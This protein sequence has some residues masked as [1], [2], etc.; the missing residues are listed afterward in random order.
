VAYWV[1]LERTDE[2]KCSGN[3]LRLK[4]RLMLRRGAKFTDG[5]NHFDYAEWGLTDEYDARPN[6]GT[7]ENPNG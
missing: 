2:I 3:A 7:K 5:R 1:A 6:Q 4:I